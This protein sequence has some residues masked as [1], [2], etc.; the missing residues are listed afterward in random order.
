MK[1]SSLNPSKNFETIGAVEISTEKEITESVEQA[2]K[3]FLQWSTITIKERSD[4]IQ[5]FVNI[6]KTQTEVIAQLVAKETGRPIKS[7]RANVTEGIRYFEEYISIADKYLSPK[8][9]IETDKELHKVY[10]EPWGVI[11]CIC[12]WN[13]PFLNIAWQ[14]GQALIAG[15]TIVY[16]NSEENP[17]FAKLIS[18]L[19]EKS[20][21]PNGVFNVIYGDGKIGDLLVH[22]DI[23]MISFTGST[24]VGQQLTKI[25]AEKFIPIVTELGGSAPGIIFEDIDIDDKL[26]EY[27]VEMRLTNNGQACDAIKR[28]IVHESRF[29]EIV[30]KVCDVMKKKKIGDAL[31]EDTDV[32]PLIAKR[33]VDL[34]EAQVKDAIEKG[35]KVEI[36][37]NTSKDLKG[38]YYSPTVL[39]NI[40]PTMRVWHEETFGPVLPIIPFKDEAQSIRQAN[41]TQYGLSAHVFTSDRKRFNRVARQLQAGSVAQNFIEYWNSNNPFGGYKKSGMGRING[42]YGFEDF[43]QPKLISEEK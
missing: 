11:A 23:N 25:A 19:I 27:I 34:I 5:S 7:A 29:E 26:I 18:E 16:K 17:L 40:N 20:D 31:S 22:Q 43:T 1:L 41:H 21:I 28:L 42:E 32:G 12:P 24:N 35:A 33:Q 37:A 6:A 30:K 39:T 14:C 4:A 8:V 15:N 36:G 13:Y 38:A 9:T 10:R 3:A 2:K